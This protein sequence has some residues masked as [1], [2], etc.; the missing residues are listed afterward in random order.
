MSDSESSSTPFSLFD[1][2]FEELEVEPTEA[3]RKEATVPASRIAATF[4][5]LV[6]QL[7]EVQSW[8]DRPSWF[9]AVDQKRLD[10]FLTDCREAFNAAE[11]QVASFSQALIFQYRGPGRIQVQ[12]DVDLKLRLGAK[13]RA[14]VLR[15]QRARS[16]RQEAQV[17]ATAAK[18]R[19]L[20]GTVAGA[21]RAE[22]EPAETG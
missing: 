16:R 4:G 11:A 8:E 6:G 18:R 10:D 17:K 15:M 9:T 3:L 1:D 14:W 21:E 12:R 5:T 20:A 22:A 2:R 7:E 13:A 19:R